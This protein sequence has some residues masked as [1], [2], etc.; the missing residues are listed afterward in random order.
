MAA[1]FAKKLPGT[2]RA[3]VLLVQ[4]Q[5]LKRGLSGVVLLRYSGARRLRCFFGKREGKAYA[6]ASACC[7]YKVWAF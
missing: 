2:T 5:S 7:K 4:K 6:A 1:S 3:A